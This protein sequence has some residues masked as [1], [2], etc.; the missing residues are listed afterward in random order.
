MKNSLGKKRTGLILDTFE[1]L[2]GHLNAPPVSEAVGWMVFCV[3]R[4]LEIQ[5]W[6][7]FAYRWEVTPMGVHEITQGDSW[8]RAAGRNSRGNQELKV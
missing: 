4:E 7:L 2:V 1:I 6:G 3:Q 8:R 5:I